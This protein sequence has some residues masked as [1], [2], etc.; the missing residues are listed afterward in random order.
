M[1]T[2]KR[3]LF[4]IKGV[5]MVREGVRYKLRNLTSCYS[6]LR[7]GFFKRSLRVQYIIKSSFPP[8]TVRLGFISD[9]V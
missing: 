5:C 8:K 6:V 7:N 2:I 3:T 9:R 1:L 4:I